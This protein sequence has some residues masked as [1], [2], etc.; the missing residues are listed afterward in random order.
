MTS[1]ETPLFQHMPMA[2]MQ[3]SQKD[4][5]MPGSQMYRSRAVIGRR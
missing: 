1:A 2:A 3:L 5:K 4:G